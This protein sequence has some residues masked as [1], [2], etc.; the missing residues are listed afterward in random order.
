MSSHHFVKEGQEPALLV[1]DA[2]ADDYLMSMLEWSPLVLVVETAMPKVAS[3]GI[4]VDAV[5]ADKLAHNDDVVYSAE[6]HAGPARIIDIKMGLA[7]SVLFFLR[8]RRQYAL[9][10]MAVSSEENFHA[11]GS[12]DDFQI[13]LVDAS[14]KWSRILS[15]RFEK[16]MP[17]AANLK[18]RADTTFEV[19]GAR[20]H[21]NQIT[22][23]RS[24]IV[25]ISSSAP[26]WI[27]EQHR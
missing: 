7:S 14:M 6:P 24:G 23:E 19:L 26:F 25:R 16:W 20:Q 15:G 27:G 5:F 11:W 13:T 2:L 21:E 1:V 9:Q 18:V 22:T 12:A 10:V 8:S 4:R 3:W 17:E